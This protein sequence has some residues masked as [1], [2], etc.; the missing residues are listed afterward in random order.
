MKH[1]ATALHL[2]LLL[3]STLV[4]CGSR[5]AGGPEPGDDQPDSDELAIFAFEYYRQGNLNA[6]P[7]GTDHLQEEFARADALISILHGLDSLARE[8][9]YF[10]NVLSNQYVVDHYEVDE[11]TG[12][13]VRMRHLFAIERFIDLAGSPLD[14]VGGASF[15]YQDGNKAA[16]VPVQSLVETLDSVDYY[17]MERAISTVTTHELGH[18][19]AALEDCRDDPWAHATYECVMADISTAKIGNDWIVISV[20]GEEV[21]GLQEDFCTHCINNIREAA[22]DWP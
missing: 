8:P 20:C 22:D 21:M 7:L 14:S 6:F 19:A 3:A 18:M 2:V 1:W 5:C 13:P 4:M 9:V 12:Y 16:F 15:S 17:W 11:Q 10:D